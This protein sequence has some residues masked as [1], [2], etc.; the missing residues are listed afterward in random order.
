M[1]GSAAASGAG[2]LRLLT[3]P[4]LF[5]TGAMV[6]ESKAI[7]AAGP[8]AYA[9]IHPDAAAALGVSE[10][11]AVNLSSPRGK[12]SVTVRVDRKTP[13][14]AVYVP[15]GAGDSPSNVLL[16]AGEPVPAVTL[17]KRAG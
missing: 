9:E 15:S 4:M 14:G 13:P 11:E 16:S 3:S 12:I 8:Q 10:G 5:S 1:S 6:A 17:E 7:Q 2:G